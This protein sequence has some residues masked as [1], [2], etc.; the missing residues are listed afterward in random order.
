MIKTTDNYIEITLKTTINKQKESKMSEFVL[1]EDVNLYQFRNKPDWE[2]LEIQRPKTD[3]GMKLGYP[4]RVILKD[5]RGDLISKHYTID[6]FDYSGRKSD[7]DIILK[8]QKR[9]FTHE[10]ILELLRN[11]TKFRELKNK[12]NVIELNTYSITYYDSTGRAHNGMYFMQD[13]E[14]LLDSKTWHKLEKEV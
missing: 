3:L 2:I 8:P 4:I 13:Y 6:G 9:P 5:K 14:Y 1:T 10:E 12:D 7:S 11:R